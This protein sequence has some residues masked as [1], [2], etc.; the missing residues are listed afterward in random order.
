MLLVRPSSN[1]VEKVFSQVALIVAATRNKGFGDTVECNFSE[2]QI[3]T[4]F[5]G[6]LTP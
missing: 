1:L 6:S 3:A 4:I 2:K 5:N